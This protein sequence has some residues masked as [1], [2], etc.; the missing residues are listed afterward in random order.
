M[1]SMDDRSGIDRMFNIG[2]MNTVWIE[3]MDSMNRVDRVGQIENIKMVNWYDECHD[4]P[5][6]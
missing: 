3:S 1:D 2:R 6:K 5:K 4:M